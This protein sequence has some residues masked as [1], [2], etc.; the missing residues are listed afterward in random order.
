MTTTTHEVYTAS[1]LCQACEIKIQGP[2][3]FSVNCHCN[4]CRRALSASFA[5]LVGFA[6]GAIEKTKGEENFVSFTTGQDERVS[7]KICSSKIYVNLHHLN[8]VA[9]Y[10][11]MFTNPNHG[12]DGKIDPKFKPSFHVFYPNGTINVLDGL[13]KFVNF[14]SA[15]GGTGETVDEKY[16]Q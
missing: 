5:T 6:A 9:V 4:F 2:V 15:F 16:H 1:C 13:P 10:Q 7:C 8:L 11:E 12:V 3:R 14:P